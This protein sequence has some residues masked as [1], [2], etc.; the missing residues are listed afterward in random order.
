LTNNGN[1]ENKVVPIVCMVETELQTGM[2]HLLNENIFLHQQ[3]CWT[4]NL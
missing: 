2:H 3:I 1:D 4:K